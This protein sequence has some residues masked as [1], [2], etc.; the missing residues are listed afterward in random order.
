MILLKLPFLFLSST[1]LEIDFKP[2]PLIAANPN[3]IDF[4][5]SFIS[6]ENKGSEKFISGFKKLIFNLSISCLSKIIFSV[7]SIE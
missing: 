6:I 2:T 4:M 7:L 3:L 5:L 1:I